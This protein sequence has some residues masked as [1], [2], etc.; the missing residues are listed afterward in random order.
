MKNLPC[1]LFLWQCRR[2]VPLVL[3]VSIPLIGSVKNLN[4]STNNEIVYSQ[5]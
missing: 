5:H 4:Y 3:S 1:V 2:A